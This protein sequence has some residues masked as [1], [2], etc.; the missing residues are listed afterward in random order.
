[1]SNV[2]NIEDCLVPMELKALRESL[3]ESRREVSENSG[4]SYS[5]LSNLE[6]GKDVQFS[7]VIKYADYL[8]YDIVL[9]KKKPVVIIDV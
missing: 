7:T 3:L 5:S 2:I 9:K 8:G 6:N 4:I 1:M